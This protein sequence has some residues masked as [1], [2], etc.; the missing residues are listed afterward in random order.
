M[1]DLPYTT[2]D[3]DPFNVRPLFQ[4]PRRRRSSLL[5]KWIEEQQQ[6]PDVRNLPPP[7]RPYIA[8]PNLASVH[9][10]TSDE[11]VTLNGYDLVEDDDIPQALPRELQIPS[12]PTTTQ[13]RRTSK[14]HTPASF[15]SFNISFRS[16]S[17]TTSQVTDG[18]SPRPSRFS[19]LPR[20]PRTSTDAACG[21]KSSNDKH[22]RS[23]SYSTINASVKGSP[24]GIPI[25]GTSSRWRPSV[26]GHFSSSSTS[27]MSVVPSDTCYTSSRP[28]MS[29]ADTYTSGTATTTESELPLTPTKM[30]FIHSIRKRSKS[31]SGSGILSSS[32]LWSQKEGI[33]AGH[34]S[35]PTLSLMNS[36]IASGSTSTLAHQS[37]AT[38]LPL[39]PKPKSRLANSNVS[40]DDDDDD[41]DDMDHGVMHTVRQYDITRPHVAYS[42][43]G[44]LPRVSLASLSSREKKKKKLVVSGVGRS[45]ARKFEGVKRWCETFGEVSQI[46]RMPNGDLHV[47]FRLAEVADTVC[48]VR[49]KVYIAGVGSVQLSWFTGDKR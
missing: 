48:R 3:E 14:L 30:N 8:Y 28:S 38:R 27:Q 36:G 25:A 32:S 40:Y 45:D 34:R 24:G 41:D 6:H 1:N 47:H 4:Q 49:A 17:P 31:Q 7:D 44:T 37:L 15:R 22:S 33:P 43:G 2:A 21:G 12:T 29:S 20:S 42:S 19:F 23:S 46:V 11:A 35:T 18:S 39:V 16:A 10:A 26:L 13:S 5:K 9:I